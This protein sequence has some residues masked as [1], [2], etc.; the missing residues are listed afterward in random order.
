MFEKFVSSGSSGILNVAIVG[1]TGFTGIESLRL[2]I[3]HPFVTIKNIVGNSFAGKEISEIYPALN[4]FDLPKIQKLEDVDFEL[5]DCVF[6]CLPHQT[7]QIVISEIIVK[8]PTIKI[9]DLSADFRLP[10]TLYE[11]VYS[12]HQAPN[13]Q[14]KS[15]Y[16]LSEIFESQIAKSQI[17][18]CPGCFPT[19]AL[20]PLIPLK[21][22]INSQV[23]IDS[24]T[25]I[26]G[27][28]RKDSFD[29]SFAQCSDAIKAYSPHNH[30]HKAEISY[31][32]GQKVRFT[33]HLV[34]ILRGIETS[35]Y[36]ES[37]SD[38]TSI[39]K[40][41]YKKSDFVKIVETL[42]STREVLAT[43]F[44]KICVIQNDTEVFISS[45]IDN[46]SKGSSSQAVQNMNIAFGFPQ[47][48]GLEFMPIIP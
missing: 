22:H 41:F 3:Q 18:A 42:P 23:V 28:G 14:E 30:R 40:E 35:I 32:F 5:I 38:C 2:L 37:N 24:K 9:I 34:P 33:P 26:T 39:L 25:G 6:C 7:S 44:C 12:K 19:C 1:V 21:N 15:C 11:E 36:F 29:F 46:I 43:N 4:Q 47:K 16:G 27:A 17:I 8:N 13:L 31:Y 10:I 45:V 48:S 20:L